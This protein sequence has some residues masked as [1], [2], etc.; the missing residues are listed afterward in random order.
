MDNSHN[1]IQKYLAW[2]D[3]NSV[4]STKDISKNKILNFQKRENSS[5]DSLLHRNKKCKFG[6]LNVGSK[7]GVR[8][9]K[10]S[11]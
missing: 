9:V 6:L 7:N 3:L 10:L 2:V 1:E 4:K 5:S 8:L 11:G